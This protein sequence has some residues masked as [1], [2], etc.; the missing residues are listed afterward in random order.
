MDQHS[1][2]APG[3]FRFYDSLKA[4]LRL[5]KPIC[6]IETIRGE[7]KKS[8]TEV[9][10]QDM[11]AGT[12]IIQFFGRKTVSS[13]AKYGISST[14]KCLL[15]TQLASMTKMKVCLELGTSLGIA[16]AYLS[17]AMPDGVVYSFEGNADLCE[18]ADSVWRRLNCNNIQLIRGDIGPSLMPTLQ[19]VGNVDFVVIDA[20]HKK[21]ALSGYFEQIYPFLSSGSIVMIDDIRWS[22]DMYKG[23]QALIADERV[24]LSV[25]FLNFGLLIFREGLSKQHYILYA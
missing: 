6:D 20:N 21:D 5:R 23:W 7:L 11:G 13:I 22:V 2:Q 9:G 16:T 19:E 24:P 1:L 18:L 4:G 10:G 17:G 25:E 12:N 3:I 15:L 14:K 8:R